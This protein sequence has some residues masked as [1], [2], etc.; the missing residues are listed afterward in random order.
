LCPN[1]HRG[2]NG[3]HSKD[4]HTLDKKIRLEY[5]NNLEILLD[6]QYF[7][8]EELKEILQISEKNVNSLC[9]LLKPIKGTFTRSDILIALCG[10]KLITIEEVEN[11]NT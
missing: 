4:G 2:R 11:D 3:V 1:C 6:K 7:T 9:K 8:Q 10:G 5:Q